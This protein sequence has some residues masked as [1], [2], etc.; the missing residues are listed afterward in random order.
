VIVEAVR[1][2]FIYEGEQVE[3]RLREHVRRGQMI[4]GV[5]VTVLVVFL[6]L[7]ELTSSLPT[8]PLREILREGL[9][10]TGW[11]AMWRPLEVL[12]YDWWP[13]IDERRQ[14]RRIL[15][16]PV[17]IRYA[18]VTASPGRQ[19]EATA[20]RNVMDPPELSGAASQVDAIE[21][22]TIAAANDYWR[23]S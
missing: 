19:S 22:Q 7:A 6:T 5:G 9:V 17:S 14:V 12:L 21:F 13:L 3:R 18:G 20:P 8:G 23:K 11:V 10:I 4:L 2:H 15:A 16:A 1:G